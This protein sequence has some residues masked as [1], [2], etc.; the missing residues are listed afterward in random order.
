MLFEIVSEKMSSIVET[1]ILENFTGKAFIFYGVI[2]IFFFDYQ[3]ELFGV[4]NRMIFFEIR[5]KSTI[6]DRV[7]PVIFFKNSQKSSILDRVNSMIFLQ[8]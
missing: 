7:N 8:N 1:V 3:L 5:Q 2:S 6:L 4:V